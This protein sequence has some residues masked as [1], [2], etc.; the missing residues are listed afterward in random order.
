M[1]PSLTLAP[2]ALLLGLRH[3]LRHSLAY[4][5]SAV[6]HQLLILI[7]YL[8]E[9]HVLRLPGVDGRHL[10]PGEVEAVVDLFKQSVDD[11]Y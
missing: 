2:L 10:R 9:E 5:Q 3:H 4:L 11:L 8:V 1:T 7:T 6:P